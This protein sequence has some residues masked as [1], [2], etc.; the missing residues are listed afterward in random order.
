MLD[1]LRARWWKLLLVVLGAIATQA[2]VERVLLDANTSF[3]GPTV[4]EAP[5]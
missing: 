4:G 2:F 5:R 3:Y 1:Y